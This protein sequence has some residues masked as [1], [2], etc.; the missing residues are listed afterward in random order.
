MLCMAPRP[1]GVVGMDPHVSVEGLFNGQS[2]KHCGRCGCWLEGE[3]GVPDVR[4]VRETASSCPY[5]VRGPVY[6]MLTVIWGCGGYGEVSP[7]HPAAGGLICSGP[8]RLCKRC[9][10]TGMIDII[11]KVRAG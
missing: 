5:W 2:R 9:E 7:N 6:R 4:R 10:G 1:D 11:R 8:E 3:C